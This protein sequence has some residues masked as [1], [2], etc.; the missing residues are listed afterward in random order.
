MGRLTSVADP[1]GRKTS[2]TYDSRQ[3]IFS[4][5]LPIGNTQYSYDAASNLTA[6]KYSDGTSLGY[7]WDPNNRLATASGL[8]LTYDSDRR[9]ASSN[10]LQIT[11]DPA[12]RIASVTYADGKAVNYTYNNRGFV[13][14]VTDWVGGNTTFT[15]D[16]AGELTAKALA[17]GITE[18]YTWDA[19]GRL[20]TITV[21]KGGTTLSS[22]SLTRDAL[23]RVT[24]AARSSANIPAEA[25]GVLP[26]A[27]DGAGQVL[28][29]TFDGLGRDT[30]DFIRSYTWDLAS[31]LTAYSGSDGSAS[32][33]YDAMGQRVS[34]TSAGATQN[35]VWNY[36]FPLP[37]L[38]TVQSGGA[39]QTYYIWLPGGTLLNSISAT[40][41][42][43]RFYH[44]DESGTVDLLTD[45]TGAVTDT[46][47]ISIYGDT[48]TQT[49]STAN[50]FTWQGR[51]GIMREGST[52]MYYMRARY[53]DS[54]PA[55]F[56]S[57]DPLSVADPRAI[58]RY[59]FV[60]GNPVENA[61]ATGMEIN[62]CGPA[63]AVNLAEGADKPYLKEEEYAFT[64]TQALKFGCVQMPDVGQP[65]PGVVNYCLTN[66][67]DLTQNTTGY[68]TGIGGTLT[69]AFPSVLVGSPAPT[70]GLASY[71]GIS[72]ETKP[73]PK[74]VST[75]TTAG[76]TRPLSSIISTVG[77]VVTNP[78][79][80]QNPGKAS[81]PANPGTPPKTSQNPIGS[82]GPNLGLG[83]RYSLDPFIS[84]PEGMMYTDPPTL[85]I[86]TGPAFIRV[87]SVIDDLDLGKHTL[88]C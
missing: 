65:P 41:S 29:E 73:A 9:I 16:A 86:E 67:F 35:Y 24:R 38:S 33:T 85:N 59:Q 18:A 74:P 30:A 82:A 31:R 17:N 12:G 25:K 3:R 52:S 36:A 49:G 10:G 60:Y 50:P 20:L 53:Y 84:A 19:D 27:Y 66:C 70:A 76:T 51:F 45:S 44:F 1:L 71:L 26:L 22:I 61:D 62:G 78:Q 32:F 23:G 7:T 34:R 88:P 46:Y 42:S 63:P 5:T 15:Y 39:D 57:R 58:N 87:E 68:A 56:L 48:V 72:S 69:I 4:A 2:F 75:S 37:C 83:S 64:L 11:R 81:C 77:D 40:D 47:A 43:R 13:S 28:G 14:Q 54:G 80:A 79:P 55:R 21:S 8:S 6:L